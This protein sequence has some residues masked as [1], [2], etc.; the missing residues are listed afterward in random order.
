M[1]TSQPSCLPQRLRC[2]SSNP[3]PWAENTV[4][5]GV[6]A[7]WWGRPPG[8]GRVLSWISGINGLCFLSLRW[9]RESLSSPLGMGSGGVMGWNQPH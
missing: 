5:Q 7:C 9:L 1:G 4:S 6:G 3:T 8:P 2:P